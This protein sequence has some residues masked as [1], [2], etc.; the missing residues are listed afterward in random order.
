[1]S[2]DKGLTATETKGKTREWVYGLAIVIIVYVCVVSS[3]S[4]NYG[5]LGFEEGVLASSVFLL[6]IGI[7]WSFHESDDG[8]EISWRLK[9]A[10]VVFL[11]LAVGSVYP[12]YSDVSRVS[13]QQQAALA[14][15]EAVLTAF[16]S[17]NTYTYIGNV[18]Q[19]KIWQTQSCNKSFLV[20]VCSSVP[21]E[22][23][24]I[25]LPDGHEL[26]QYYSCNYFVLGQVVKVSV[27]PIVMAVLANNQTAS[28][29]GYAGVLSP[30]NQYIV[31][32]FVYSITAV[33]NGC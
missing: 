12:T 24:T 27:Y 20:P 17:A 29:Q 14:K 9:L 30:T 18:T 32:H 13:N 19:A 28:A 10:L 8:Y 15:Q 2:N 3:L 5:S 31:S 22:N 33:P 16:V 1:M 25:A 26:H 6:I 21:N 11:I 23:I 7:A 4:L